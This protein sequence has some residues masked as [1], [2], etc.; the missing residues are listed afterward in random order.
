MYQ[1]QLLIMAPTQYVHLH[2]HTQYSLLD[3]AC[4]IPKLIQKAVDNKMPALGMTDHGN[5]F[6]AIDFYQTAV[7]M[8]VKPI[9][10]CEAYLLMTGNRTERAPWQRGALSHLVLFARNNEGYRSLLKLVSSSYLEGFY[11]FPRIDKDLLAQHA[12]V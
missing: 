3:G 1:S 6:G 5:I 11:Y 2:V 9:I 7:K 4:S 12:S 10:G 8:G